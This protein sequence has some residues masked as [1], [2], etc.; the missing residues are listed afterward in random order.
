MRG[1]GPEVRGLLT[2]G[3]GLALRIDV[4]VIA[5]AVQAWHISK[6]RRGLVTRLG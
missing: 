1:F 4:P 6:R 2:I 5:A 3:G